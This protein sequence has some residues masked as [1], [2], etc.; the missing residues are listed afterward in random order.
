MVHRRSRI[1]VAQYGLGAIGIE[2]ARLVRAKRSLELVGV[3]EIDPAKNREV[4]LGVPIFAG[5]QDLIRH[6][7]PDV[8]LHTTGSRI[9][10]IFSQLSE[11]A[12]AGIPCVSSAEELFH[13]IGPNRRLASEINK[14]AA[15][16]GV[17]IAATG[18]NPGFVMDLLPTLLTAACRSIR[19][20]KIRRIVDVSKRR[21][22]L[23]RKV[24]LGMSRREFTRLHNQGKMGHVG[25]LESAAFVADA[26]GIKVSKTAESLCP[27]MRC[28]KV[29]GIHQFVRGMVGEREVLTLELGMTAGAS[30][31]RDEIEIDGDPPIHIVIPGGVCGDQ[32]TAAIL[33]N[34]IPLVLQAPPGLRSALELRMPRFIP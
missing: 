13:P 21:V 29:T 22:Q 4:G 6:A 30:N 28:G 16:K 17:T 23:Q 9:R 25:L 3:V 26:I 2:S 32:A 20:V 8:I 24:G 12:S 19:K 33:V 14:I 11:I 15:S 27:A 10:A 1:R 18:V 5:L 31:P 34:S 7:G